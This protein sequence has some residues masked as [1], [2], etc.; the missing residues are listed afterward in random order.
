MIT[1]KKLDSI[2][3]TGAVHAL[4]SKDGTWYHHLNDFPGVLFDINGFLI[5]KSQPDYLNSPY[6]HH[7]Q[8]LNIYDGISAIP[9]YQK[10]T[11]EEKKRI[12]DFL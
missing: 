10:F 12:T 6:L 5:F 9:G 4:Y 11:D 1:A 3:K 7:G 2:I 8:H